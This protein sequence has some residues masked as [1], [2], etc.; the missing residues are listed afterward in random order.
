MVRKIKVWGK[1]R[2]VS[3]E[4]TLKEF[5]LLEVTKGGKICICS[6]AMT[7]KELEKAKKKFSKIGVG[8]R[9]CAE[10]KVRSR[11]MALNDIEK[12]RKMI[13]DIEGK[14]NKY[15][16][17]DVIKFLDGVEKEI[18][19]SPKPEKLSKLSHKITNLRADIVGLRSRYI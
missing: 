18:E 5:K 19:S 12:I 6:A 11:R 7:V 13:G 1:G 14:T 8:L 16:F 15:K 4:F 2:K 10:E 3:E 17:G 9:P